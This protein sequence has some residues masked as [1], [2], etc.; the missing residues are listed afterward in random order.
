MD[1]GGGF[2]RDHM[3][4]VLAF[5]AFIILG[6]IAYKNY[7]GDALVKEYDGNYTYDPGTYTLK[8]EN[9]QALWAQMAGSSAEKCPCQS[10]SETTNGLIYLAGT[11]QYKASCFIV[12]WN[13]ISSDGSS[14][15]QNILKWIWHDEGSYKGYVTLLNLNELNAST[16]SNEDEGQLLS[17]LIGFNDAVDYPEIIAPFTFRFDNQNVGSQ[18]VDENGANA[19][20]KIVIVDSTGTV[21]ITFYHVANWIC[22]GPPMMQAQG[23][24]E[25]DVSYTYEQWLHHGKYNTNLNLDS[26]LNASGVV[27]TY[28]YTII[29]NSGNSEVTSGSAGCAI[30]YIDKDKT[31]I[32]I[33]SWNSNLNVWETITFE[34]FLMK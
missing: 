34:D 27:P 2:N 23:T 31:T 11:R 4:L 3:Y 33:E 22:A 14:S 29:G 15:K 25:D 17:S 16:K 12:P 13:C 30:G 5:L 10:I 7:N 18:M 26:D 21:R 24:S 9:S 6:V 19:G 28:H 32:K 20:E 1:Q 8:K